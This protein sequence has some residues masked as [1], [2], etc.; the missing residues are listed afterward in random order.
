MNQK[1]LSINKSKTICSLL[2]VL[3]S[4]LC[5][6]F[7]FGCATSGNATFI[8]TG[9]SM[10]S[11]PVNC[12]IKVFSS[13]IPERKYEELGLLEI[14][15][16]LRDAVLEI[17]LPKLKEKACNIGADAIIIKSI[18]KYMDESNIENLYVTATA[19]VWV[20]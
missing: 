5:I 13:K 7:L 8:K 14:E 3:S 9:P 17:V 2:L 10:T 1:L 20:E 18:Q 16:S 19:I 6:M 11:K 4:L 12:A 15:G